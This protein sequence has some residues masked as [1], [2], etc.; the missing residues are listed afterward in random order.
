MNITNVDFKMCHYKKHNYF[1][2]QQQNVLF[3]WTGV[4]KTVSQK[5][6]YLLL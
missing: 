6:P 1:K 2:S 4:M 3:Y 5:K